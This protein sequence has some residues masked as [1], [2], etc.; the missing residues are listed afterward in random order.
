M[1]G[2]TK[3]VLLM[4]EELVLLPTDLDIACGSALGAF[5]DLL[6][7]AVFLDGALVAFARALVGAFVAFVGAFVGV[8]VAFV[9]ALVGCLVGAFER[10]FVGN[11]ALVGDVVGLVGDTVGY[12]V[13]FRRSLGALMETSDITLGAWLIF[14]GGLLRRGAGSSSSDAD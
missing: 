7:A 3:V 5:V 2:F 1:T 9:G 11:L 14:S 13:R 4:A 10:A 6:S 12:R 8:L